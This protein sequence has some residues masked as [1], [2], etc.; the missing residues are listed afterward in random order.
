MQKGIK[1]ISDLKELPKTEKDYSNERMESLRVKIFQSIEDTIGDSKEYTFYEIMDSLLKI[2][3]S[4]NKRFLDEQF[5]N[6]NEIEVN[7]M[8]EVK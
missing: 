3:Y 5:K 6:I 8:Q 2:G 7:E 1:N 4:Y